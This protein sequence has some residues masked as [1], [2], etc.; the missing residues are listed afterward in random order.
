MIPILFGNRLNCYE[1]RN[2]VDD[3]DDDDDNNNN[4]LSGYLLTCRLN[5][6]CLL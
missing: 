5:S 6:E 1:V 4:N 3:D 2:V